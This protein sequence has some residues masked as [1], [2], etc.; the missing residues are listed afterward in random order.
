MSLHRKANES[1]GLVRLPRTY[2]YE[3]SE[4]DEIVELPDFEQ[5]SVGAPNPHII[6]NEGRLYLFYY[7]QQSEPDWDGTSVKVVGPDTEDETVAIVSFDRVL[8]HYFGAPN[9]EAL[10]GHPLREHGLLPYSQCEVRESSWI[11]NFEKL[12][13]V[14]RYHK[15]SLFDGYRHFIFVFHDSVFECIARNIKT[16]LRAGSIISAIAETLKSEAL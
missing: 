9:E 14:H 4:S 13:R 12:N 2:I 3:P 15:A 16:N 7:V 1:S 5:A 6:C 10:D 11:A 8:A